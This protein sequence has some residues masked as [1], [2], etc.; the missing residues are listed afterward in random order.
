[1]SEFRF[2]DIITHDYAEYG[3]GRYRGKHTKYATHKSELVHINDIFEGC[4]SH[5]HHYGV[6]NSVERFIEMDISEQEES[7]KNKFAELFH[8][9]DLEKCIDELVD[10]VIGCRNNDEVDRK[11][12]EKRYR[13]AKTSIQETQDQQ[14]HR[15]ALVMILQ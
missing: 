8:Q 13:S 15:L 5:A 6:Y 11:A 9:G 3:M 10:N 14:V 1:M 4:E 2:A 7:N 12:Y